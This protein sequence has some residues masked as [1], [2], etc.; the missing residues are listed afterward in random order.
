[1]HQHHQW[2]GVR[3]SGKKNKLYQLN[4]YVE[5]HPILSKWLTT[6][7]RKPPKSIIPFLNGF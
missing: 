5:D 6:L 4:K 2:Y 3:T 7:A 1:M